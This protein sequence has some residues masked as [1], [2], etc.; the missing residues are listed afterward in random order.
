MKSDL[1]K[2]DELTRRQ[3]MAN[4][5]KTYLGVGL[6]PMLGASLAGKAMAQT[7]GK[8]QPAEA[9][10]F[11]N[12]S[13][14]MSHIDTFDVKP[15]NKEIQGPVNAIGTSADGIQISQYLPKTAAVMDKICVIRSM[16]NQ[17]GD[18]FRGQYMLHRNYAPR[19]T[20]T[21]PTVGAWVMKVKGRKNKDIPGFVTVGTSAGHA[22]PGFF[23]V[24]YGGVPLGRPDEGLKDS[25]IAGSVSVEDFDRRLKLA[26]ALNKEFHSKHNNT[27]ALAYDELYDEAV[28]LMKS[29]D[30][31]AFDIRDEPKSEREAYGEHA[32]G[33]GCMLARRLVE[34]GVRY[35]EVGLGGWDT[36][37]DNFTAV[38]ARCNVLDQA[39]AN[40]LIDL[41]AKGLLDTTIVALSTE[42]GRTPQI[43]GDRKNG[44]N[45]HPRAYSSLLAGG[46]IKGGMVYGS[47]D[48]DGNSVK[49]DRVSTEDFNATI[50]HG[51]GIDT[52]SVLL[53]PSGRPFKIGGKNGKPVKSLYS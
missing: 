1:N 41:E 5:A 29:E 50:A 12:M 25:T 47:T 52:T 26:D 7:G 9:V 24:K 17:N 18:H 10:I 35:V 14:G 40:L 31:K 36:H 4:A 38:E 51:M 34:H 8:S 3:F 46:G 28:R 48:A 20:I 30:L 53:S 11:L 6:S 42:F 32:F 23:G 22:S 27:E 19:A 43:H 44:R 39:Y 33:Q 15:G 13:G 37:Y 2:T 49:K 45:H 21:H 16:S